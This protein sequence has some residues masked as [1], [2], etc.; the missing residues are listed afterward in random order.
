MRDGIEPAPEP[1][2]RVARGAPRGSGSGMA[3]LQPGP[4]GSAGK[5]S[6]SLHATRGR[7]SRDQPRMIES[8]HGDYFV[9]GWTFDTRARTKRAPDGNVMISREGLYSQVCGYGEGSSV[10]DTLDCG[11]VKRSG[12]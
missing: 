3:F 8:G 7:V 12:M 9:S 6:G 10:L 1:W 5:R 4:G 11:F 2:D